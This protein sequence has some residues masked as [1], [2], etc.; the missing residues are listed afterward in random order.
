MLVFVDNRTVKVWFRL[1]K[2]EKNN[3]YTELPGKYPLEYTDSRFHR[4]YELLRIGGYI[5]LEDGKTPYKGK[6][7]DI[8]YTL[9]EKNYRDGIPLENENLLKVDWYNL[10]LK[11]DNSRVYNKRK[12]ELKV[13]Q[14]LSENVQYFNQFVQGDAFTKSLLK[15]VEQYKAFKPVPPFIRAKVLEF[16]ENENRARDNAR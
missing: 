15:A 12:D 11:L 7:I 1:W 16:I 14:E 9:A 4:A 2:I 13:D 10:F 8:D 6:P 5:A 3:R